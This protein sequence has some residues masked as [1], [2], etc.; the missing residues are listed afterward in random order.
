MKKCKNCK[1]NENNKCKKNVIIEVV[2]RKEFA[3][4]KNIK[5][6]KACSHDVEL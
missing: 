1:Y 6:I 5:D 4:Y 2:N 3:K